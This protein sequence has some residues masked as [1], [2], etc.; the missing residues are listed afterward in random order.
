MNL[1]GASNFSTSTNSSG[2]FTLSNVLV[3]NYTLA[4][5]KEDDI[6]GITAYD[7]SLVIRHVAGLSILTGYSAVAADVDN[8]GS[9]GTLDSSYILQK[10]VGLIGVPFPG[11]RFGVE[12]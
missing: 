6:D 12:I 1:N 2:V 8:S 9:I 7:A 10:A 3:G 11:I 5:G 4:P